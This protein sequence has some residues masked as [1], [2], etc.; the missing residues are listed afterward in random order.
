MCFHGSELFFYQLS[1]LL[2]STAG[3]DFWN[4]HL[5]STGTS[6][7]FQ[8]SKKCTRRLFYTHRSEYLSIFVFLAYIYTLDWLSFYSCFLKIMIPCC[9]VQ[10]RASGMRWSFCMERDETIN[11]R[12]AAWELRDPACKRQSGVETAAKPHL[13]GCITLYADLYCG[14]R[15]PCKLVFYSRNKRTELGLLA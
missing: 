3:I 8:V 13:C 9:L 12:R 11:L 5:N 7:T 6:K 10:R 1:I 15:L 2:N 4:N 14:Y